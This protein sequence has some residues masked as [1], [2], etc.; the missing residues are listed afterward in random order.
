MY[1]HLLFF[2]FFIV[3]FWNFSEI[4]SKKS[5]IFK[6]MLSKNSQNKKKG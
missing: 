2:G 1:T 5:L 4:F 6:E 3:E